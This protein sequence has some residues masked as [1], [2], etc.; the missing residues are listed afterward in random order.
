MPIN[1]SP[2][3]VPTYFLY[4]PQKPAYPLEIPL[5]VVH[6]SAVCSSSSSFRRP[7]GGVS[8]FL[9]VNCSFQST[10]SSPYGFWGRVPPCIPIIVIF[11]SSHSLRTSKLTCL[12]QVPSLPWPPQ[13]LLFFPVLYF[14]LEDLVNN[15][16][17]CV[18]ELPLPQALSWLC[19]HHTWSLLCSPISQDTT[20]SWILA[21]AHHFNPLAAIFNL[22]SLHS[23]QSNYSPFCFRH[24]GG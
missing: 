12:P 10:A 2:S 7:G 22:L 9:S 23:P 24:T 20:Y 18:I 14:F 4:F 11:H 5:P 16:N 3:L 8:V 13:F 17:C 6:S 15:L 19:T 1:S 21:W